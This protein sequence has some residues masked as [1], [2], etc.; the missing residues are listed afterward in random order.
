MDAFGTD[1]E[2][3]TGWTIKSNDPTILLIWLETLEVVPVQM[4]YST[5]Y[6][7]NVE[8]KNTYNHGLCT[9]SGILYFVYA[10]L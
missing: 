4:K 7:D 9:N 8:R 6:I 2:R 3:K 1:K 10:L 5:N